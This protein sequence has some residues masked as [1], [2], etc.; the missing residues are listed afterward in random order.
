MIVEAN[1]D[2]KGDGNNENNNIKIN[3]EEHKK[4]KNLDVIV[5][6]IIMIVKNK[7]YKKSIF[8]L[9]KLSYFNYKKIYSKNL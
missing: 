2:N 3:K 7:I 8:H 4:K 1:L 6:N 9:A 5:K